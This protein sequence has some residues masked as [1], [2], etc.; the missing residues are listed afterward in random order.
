VS[1]LEQ[2]LAA[3]RS[4]LSGGSRP[5][6]RLALITSLRRADGPADQIEMLAVTAS[7]AWCVRTPL[8]G[9]EVAPNGT[10]DAVAALFAAHWIADGDIADALAK[11]ASSV[12]AVLE[13]TREAGERELQL[14]AA[15]ERWVSPSRHFRPE[16]V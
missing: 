10:G 6:P 3:A 14:V 12:F 2:A 1:T 16:R 8:I 9:F 7:T 4:L 13:A 11:A 5:G 15:Q